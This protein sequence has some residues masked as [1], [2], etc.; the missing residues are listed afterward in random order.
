MRKSLPRGRE[1]VREGGLSEAEKKSLSNALNEAEQLRQGRNG[2]TR[3]AIA[4]AMQGQ[5][6]AGY[7]AKAVSTAMIKVA[8]DPAAK[9]P[10]RIEF[11]LSAPVP[12]TAMPDS[13]GRSIPANQRCAKPGHHGQLADACT[14][15]KVD[16]AVAAAE[17]E[18]QK[19]QEAHKNS[20]NTSVADK[21][22]ECERPLTAREHALRAAAAGKGAQKRMERPT[23]P[24]LPKQDRAPLVPASEPVADISV[25]KVD[26]RERATPH[27]RAVA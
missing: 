3:S 23:L 26:N 18:Q 22:D 14:P 5:V 1:T 4:A 10:A 15:C 2:W 9:F 20:F 12:S 16:A 7:S 8:R 6:D 27:I 24:H 19:A 25:T 13:Y 17:V 11:V 21:A